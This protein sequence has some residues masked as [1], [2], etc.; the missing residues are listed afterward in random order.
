MTWPRKI[1]VAT[2]G[3][4]VYCTENFSDPSIQPVWTAINA[5]LPTLDCA[6]FDIDPHAPGYRQFVMLS[7]S[8]VIYRREGGG[9]WTSI[10]TPAQIA[11]MVGQSVHVHSFCVDKSVAGRLWVQAG[12]VAFWEPIWGLYTDDY[13]DNWTVVVIRSGWYTYSE[14]G[15]R[16]HGDNVFARVNSGSGSPARVYYSTNKGSSWNDVQIDYNANLPLDFNPLLPNQCYCCSDALGNLDHSRV[17]NSGVHTALQDGIHMARYDSM[18]FDPDDANHQRLLSGDKMYSTDD[19][20]A[21]RNS[22]SSISPVP[23]SCCQY[24]GTDSNNMIVGLTLGTHAVG[25]L[26]G[27]LDTSPTGIAGANAG[28]APY[29]DS[30]PS[31]CG[32]VVQRG[33]QAVPISLGMYTY[34]VEFEDAA[35]DDTAHPFGVSYESAAENDSVHTSDV[36]LGD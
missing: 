7:S 35:E 15:I 22:P 10:L 11:S 2:Y 23:T 13:G 14:W 3:L 17:T 30:I 6:W 25:V 28:S 32:G 29:T 20:W 1:F 4:G 12:A 5:G 31:N 19:E 26:E 34:D 24:S 33:V 21:T 27:E 9:S 36:E 16:S 8:K 18:W